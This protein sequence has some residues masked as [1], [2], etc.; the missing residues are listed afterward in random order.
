MEIVR[1]IVDNEI[2]AHNSQDSNDFM[3]TNATQAIDFLWVEKCNVFFNLLLV[4]I[5]VFKIE[6]DHCGWPG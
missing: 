1:N 2:V 5:I 4:N 3:K 6:P